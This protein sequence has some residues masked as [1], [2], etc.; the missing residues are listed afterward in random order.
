MHTY[1][2]TGLVLFVILRNDLHSIDVK[3]YF[4]KYMYLYT[5][6]CTYK[7]LLIFQY[8]TQ[9]LKNCILQ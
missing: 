7:Y 1:V 4:V 8:K 9:L 5:C 6:S 3:Q 2:I